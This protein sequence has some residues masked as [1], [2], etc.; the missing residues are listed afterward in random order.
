MH[1]SFNDA[2]TES[3]RSGSQPGNPRLV[4][5]GWLLPLALGTLV[6]LGP[7]LSTALASAASS[8]HQ[9]T[10][11]HARA[12]HLGLP[13]AAFMTNAYDISLALTTTLLFVALGWSVSLRKRVQEQTERIHQ[14]LE[15]ESNLEH[16]YT[17]SLNR[18]MT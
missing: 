7:N 18:P 9:T 8:D 17:D 14:Q 4:T 5:P 3:G 10:E 13:T 12:W 11:P 6:L 16:K 15:R 2:E 1:Y